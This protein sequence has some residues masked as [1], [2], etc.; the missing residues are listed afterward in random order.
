MSNL[1]GK[2]LLASPALE[3]PNFGRAVILLVEHGAEGSLGLVLN[4]PT[5]VSVE[6][7][8]PDGLR[9]LLS[10]REQ[11]D[12]LVLRHGGP[13]RGPLMV[14]HRVE[15]AAQTL[16]LPGVFFTS[17]ADMVERALLAA[18]DEGSGDT[19]RRGFLFFAGYAG[20]GPGQLEAEIREEAWTVIGS[21][22]EAVFGIDG[23]TWT[24]QTRAT[25]QAAWRA[26][27]NPR[28]VPPDASLN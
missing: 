19:D 1:Q 6:Q 10:S 3:D 24:R 25:R 4:K 28:I 8:V 15:P 27:M 12:E 21:D 20:W 7:V 2:L 18:A 13:C 14:L 16:V 26:S 9:L 17:D 11:A 5:E 23:S 22:A